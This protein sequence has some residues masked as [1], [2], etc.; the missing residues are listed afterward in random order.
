MRVQNEKKTKAIHI[1]SKTG[2]PMLCV[3]TDESEQMKICNLGMSLLGGKSLRGN[4]H[5]S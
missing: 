1:L 4:L 3:M 5:V 2:I